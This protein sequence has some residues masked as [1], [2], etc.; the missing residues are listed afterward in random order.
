[1]EGLLTLN[2]KGLYCPIGDFYIDPWKPVKRAL[3]THAHG[4]HLK[5]GSKQYYT[6]TR[7]K[8]IVEHRIRQENTY[9]LR[10]YDFDESFSING[11]SISFHPAGHVLGSAQ[12]RLEYQGEVWVASGDYKRA[13]DPTCMPFEIQKCDVFISEATFGVPIYKWEPGHLVASKIYEWW[14]RNVSENKPSVLFVYA[15]GKAQRV[16][17]ELNK[18][19]DNA[20]YIH[21]ALGAI[22]GL[23]REQGI[24]MLDTRLV[25]KQ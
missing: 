8:L 23:Y 14:E 20:V 18:L 1:M 16:L 12:V 22:T 9:E 17:A 3:I 6:T 7:G 4:D 5:S 11:V 10:K 21:G 15:L 25:S 2:D 24:N 13:H 19:T